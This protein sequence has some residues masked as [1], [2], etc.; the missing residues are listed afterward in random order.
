MSTGTFEPT[1]LNLSDR[2]TLDASVASVLNLI[3]NASADVDVDN[4]HDCI[5]N[6]FFNTGTIIGGHP[7]MLWGERGSAIVGNVL[8][9][10]NGANNA[11]VQPQQPQAG[12]IVA[13]TGTCSASTTIDWTLF[14]NGVAQAFVLSF[15]AATTAQITGS[16]PFAANDQVYVQVTSGSSSNTNSKVCIFIIYD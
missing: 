9:M 1:S 12:H 3:G 6:G 13:I 16:I 7:I 11:S 10:G 15:V 2:V 5:T 8:A 14:I 4:V